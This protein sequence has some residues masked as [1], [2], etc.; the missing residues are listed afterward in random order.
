MVLQ[1]NF[2]VLVES[3]DLP[4]VVVDDDGSVNAVCFLF[5]VQMN[6]RSE[7]LIKCR[8]HCFG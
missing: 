8:N 1:W 2:S 5:L 6:I 7:N 3:H 4:V